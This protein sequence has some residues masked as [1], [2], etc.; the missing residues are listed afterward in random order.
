MHTELEEIGGLG[1]IAAFD[2]CPAPVIHSIDS[3]R[4][5]VIGSAMTGRN[6]QESKGATNSASS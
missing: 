4:E 5:I 1:T 3:S 2:S 6:E